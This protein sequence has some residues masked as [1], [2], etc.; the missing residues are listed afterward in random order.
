MPFGL[1]PY[2]L[3]ALNVLRIEKGHA[4]TGELNGNLT[5]RDLGLGRMLSTKK[6][7]V[8]AALAGRPALT[9]AD[10]PILVGFKPINPASPIG[11]G[12]HFIRPG[13][14]LKLRSDEG[15]LTSAC[16]SPTLH[17]HIGLGVIVRGTQRIG[18]QVRAYDP[19]RKRDTLVEICQPVFVDPAG[20]R[21]RG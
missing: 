4:A 8:G 5:A 1:L 13:A 7:Y 19:L 10:R 14:E 11:A 3:E 12:A 6:D 15:Y 16:W 20:E 18:E 17:S 21:L 9:A 2:G